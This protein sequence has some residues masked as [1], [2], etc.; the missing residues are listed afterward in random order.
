MN[1]WDRVREF[2][3]DRVVGVLHDN[4]T[5]REGLFNHYF[6][7]AKLASDFIAMITRLGF[8]VLAAFYFYKKMYSGDGISVFAFSFCMVSSIFLLLYLST[9][10]SMVIYISLLGQTRIPDNLLGRI[11]FIIAAAT[12]AVSGIFGI[13]TLASDLALKAGLI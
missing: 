9:R 11:I 6:A 3:R 13:S 8:C 4:S 2:H 1:L 12:L 5:N 10:M 7:G